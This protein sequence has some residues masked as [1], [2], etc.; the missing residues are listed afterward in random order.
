MI[1]AKIVFN[2]MCTVHFWFS[3]WLRAAHLTIKINKNGANAKLESM[4]YG[5][6]EWEDSSC[7]CWKWLSSAVQSNRELHTCA[8]ALSFG[9]KM[10]GWTEQADRPAGMQ[11]PELKFHEIN[12]V[13]RHF[14]DHSYKVANI[15]TQKQVHTQQSN[16]QTPFHTNFSIPTAAMHVCV[17]VR[18][19]S[20]RSVSFSCLFYQCTQIY[21]N[22]LLNRHCE[23]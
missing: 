14:N 21:V 9:E 13:E 15:S 10:A 18:A 11:A 20:R 12:K 4:S 1:T 3:H 23:N 22:T 17:C 16:M 8:C 7:I 19:P 5:D 6:C 2:Y